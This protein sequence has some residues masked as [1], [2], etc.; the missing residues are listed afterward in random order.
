MPKSINRS[1]KKIGCFLLRVLS[2]FLITFSSRIMIPSIQLNLQRSGCL[3]IMLMFCNGQVN[4]IENL[5]RF[6]KI[7]IW[8]RA[9]ADIHNLKTIYQEEWYKIST[10]YCKKLIENYWKRLVA[11]E[12]NKGYSTKYQM[13]IMR[14][15]L[16]CMITFFTHENEYV[17]NRSW[18]WPEVSL[19]DSY[20]TKV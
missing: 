3:K 7:Q 19:F 14:Y 17:G 1:S 12:V 15:F 13:K 5:W 18:V 20:Y 11:I 6:L 10:K 8:K 16:Y 2:Y 4:P 9:P